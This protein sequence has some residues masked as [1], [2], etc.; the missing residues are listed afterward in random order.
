[1]CVVH[2]VWT[3]LLLLVTAGVAAGV[4]YVLTQHDAVPQAGRTPGYSEGS[5]P[6][7]PTGSPSGP[8]PGTDPSTDPGSSA[9][10]DPTRTVFLGDDYTAGVGA[11]SPG[12]GW[13]DQVALA[14]HLHG[15][16]IAE[17]GAG[18]AKRGVDASSYQDLLAQVV[19]ARPNVVIVSGGRNDAADD[20][21]TLRSAARAVFA[22]LHEQLPDA[23]LLAI[24]PFWGDSP[25]PV[26]LTKVDRAVRAGVEAAGG[27][28]LDSGD[29]LTGHPEWMA[30][31][32]DPNDRGYAAIATAL[33]AALRGSLPH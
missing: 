24:A 21:A 6:A 8:L 4:V 1:M 15:E 17:A 19:A 10:A 16:S 32:A 23:T 9:P 28:Y 27:T 20:P 13:T 12:R 2:R 31:A 22:S 18:Y 14:L 5:L 3:A 7:D 29:P 30:D 26:K 25:H 11:S 33:T